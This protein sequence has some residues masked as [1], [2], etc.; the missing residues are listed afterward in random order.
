MPNNIVLFRLSLSP[1]AQLRSK[2]FNH[3]FPGFRVEH[4]ALA[5]RHSATGDGPPRA[6][7]AIRNLGVPS[8]TEGQH[9]PHRKRTSRQSATLTIR[10]F[11]VVWFNAHRLSFVGFA[12]LISAFGESFAHHA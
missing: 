4:N 2:V 9:G 12:W 3:A 7:I 10:P 5:L 6:L 1:S 8:V 11:P